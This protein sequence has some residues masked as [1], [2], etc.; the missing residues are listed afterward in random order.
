MKNFTGF[1]I[2]QQ[3]L[4]RGMSQEDLCRGICA[5]SYLSKIEQGLGNP[6]PQILQQLL[7][8]LD[9]HYNH[10]EDQLAEAQSN[11]DSYFDKYFH[12]ETAER[13]TAYLKLHQQEMENSE[14][15]LSWHLF[16]LYSLIQKYG[17]NAPVCHQE[18]AYLA[19]FEEYMET[20]QLFYYYTGA[21]LVESEEQL[22]YL[23]L[24][25]TIRPSSFVKQNIAEVYYTRHAYMD[26]IQAADQAYRAAAEEGSLPILLWSSYL[27]GACYANFDDLSFMLRYY[28][29]ARE[30]SRGYDASIGSLINYQ[31]GSAYL[32]HAQYREA[33]PYLLDSLSPRSASGDDQRFLTNQKLSVCYF[34]EGYA[35]LG[36]QY[37][38]EASDGRSE[39][40]PD[41]YDQ[42]LYLTN[43]RY[44]QNARESAE[45]ESVLKDI[46]NNCADILGDGY[47]RLLA[48]YLI[49]YYSSQR[50]YKEA[51]IIKS[52]YGVPGAKNSPA[53]EK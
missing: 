35:S 46:Y 27:L 26:A 40:M 2:R 21:G 43:L 36:L 49:Q 23:R 5:V 29:R 20:E 37:L 33:I 38:Q 8:A 19:R 51:L 12:S 3:R 34:E 47:R 11:L 45:Y 52:E 39:R 10:D 13:E 30:L 28:K 44:V 31:I 9:I 16:Q 32:E 25:E 48:E 53:S 50:K 14:L 18:L 4:S 15:H 24:A 22:E 1:I 17:K 6:S 42:L 7:E 41:L